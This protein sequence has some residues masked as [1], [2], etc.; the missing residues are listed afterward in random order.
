MV[1]V[2][3]WFYYWEKQQQQLMRSAQG[4]TK[5]LYHPVRAT[6]TEHHS[7]DDLNNKNLFFHSS[8]GWTSKIKVLAVLVSGEMALLGLRMTTFSLCLYLAFLLFV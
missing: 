2:H 1:I 4:A 3:F 6:L 5:A 7:L 8:R